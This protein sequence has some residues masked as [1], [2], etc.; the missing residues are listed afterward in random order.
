[1]V[2]LVM[3]TLPG[4]P[5]LLFLSKSQ[6][7]SLSIE[8]I[9][10]ARHEFGLDKPIIEQ[11]TGWVFGLFRG[12]FG[13]SL[14]YHED[15]SKLFLQRWPITL[16]IGILAFIVGNII[17]ILAGVLSAVKRG[18]KLDLI[19]TLVANL[20][21]TIPVFWLGIL[22]IFAFGLKLKWLPLFGYTSPL[23]DFWMSTKQLI[24]PVICLSIFTIGSLARQARS[25]ML[26]VM[27]QDYIRTAWAKGLKERVIVAR[28]AL[29][30]GLIPIVT[31]S[32]MGLSYILGG[33]VLVE[34]VFNI[35][36]IGRLAVDA[37]LGLDYS[38]IQSITL[39][40]SAIIVLMNFIVDI[41]YG[42]LDPRIRYG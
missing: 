40:I 42:W 8:Q 11:Y 3:H 22:M 38:L 23:E 19:M 31:L 25:S 13:K 2:F 30:N 20:G 28:H 35:T 41:S 5:V 34:T 7:D 1:M 10:S 36:G 21:I 24:M 33:S 27:G 17:G 32:G 18:K 14:L 16:H 12:D 39:I 26:E 29:K 15:V 9:E 6:Y 37:I 4:D